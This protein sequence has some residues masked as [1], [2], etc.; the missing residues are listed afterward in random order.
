MSKWAI[1][2]ASES[3]P[4]TAGAR[5]EVPGHREFNA[6]APEGRIISDGPK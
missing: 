4:E 6:S 5:G 2:N 3:C 1:L